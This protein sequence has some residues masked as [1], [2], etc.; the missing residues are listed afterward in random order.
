MTRVTGTPKVY[1][2]SVLRGST[3]AGMGWM[4]VIAIRP[5]TQHMPPGG[6]A[7]LLA[8]GVAYTFGIVFYLWKRLPFHHAIWHLFVLAGSLCQFFAI[9]FYVVLYPT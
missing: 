9:M 3:Y 8:G 6:I 4:V 1:T 2:D 7:W 5:L